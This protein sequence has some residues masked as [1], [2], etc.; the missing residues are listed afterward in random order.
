MTRYRSHESRTDKLRQ[1]KADLPISV[2]A[3]EFEGEDNHEDKIEYICKH[4]RRTLIKIHEEGEYYCNECSIAVFPEVDKDVR[5]KHKLV[6]PIGL[7]MEPCLSYLPEP[8]DL[9]RPD[10]QIKGD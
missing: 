6:T 8:N 3:E 5:S 10:V 9:S 2:S 7:N 1:Q 4:C